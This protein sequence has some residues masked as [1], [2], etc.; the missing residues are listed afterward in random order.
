MRGGAVPVRRHPRNLGFELR[1]PRPQLGLR[2]GVEA[3]SREE[4][5]RVASRARA[6]V[7]IHAPAKMSR[8]RLAVNGRR[9]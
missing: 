8:A 4:A 1:D 2:V 5:C 6:I 3:F 9:G 7:I